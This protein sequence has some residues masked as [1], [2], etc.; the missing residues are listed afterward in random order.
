MNKIFVIPT[1]VN[2]D[3]KKM[4]ISLA[5][6]EGNLSLEIPKFISISLESEKLSIT[7]ISGVISSKKTL[8]QFR[9]FCSHFKN[10]LKG[11]TIGHIRQLKLVGVGYR[12]EN[13]GNPDLTL[14]LGY[15]KPIL[16]KKESNVAIDV[17]KPTVLQL[18]GSHL[19]KISQR[20]SRIQQLR[21]PEPY[22][23]KGIF[24]KGEVIKRKEGKKIN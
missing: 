15:S 10:A 9:T 13:S 6:P 12:A 21:P 20:A 7:A 14:R 24:L 3:I 16:I 8:A 11:I 4:L 22:K 2:V 5:G 23:G 1:S 17:V 18:R 19:Q